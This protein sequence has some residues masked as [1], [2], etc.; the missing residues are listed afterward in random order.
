MK[1]GT[2]LELYYK[3]FYEY[4]KPKLV[5]QVKQSLRF[6]IYYFIFILKDVWASER[7]F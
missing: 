6:L 4:I 7:E 5:F 3:L 1:F 2:F